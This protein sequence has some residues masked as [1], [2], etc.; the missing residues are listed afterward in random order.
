MDKLVEQQLKDRAFK[1]TFKGEVVTVYENKTERI[2]ILKSG[3]F[4][5]GP[6]PTVYFEPTVKGDIKDLDTIWK[7]K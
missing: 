2:V 4:L 5:Y 6:K 1:I 7:K 3:R